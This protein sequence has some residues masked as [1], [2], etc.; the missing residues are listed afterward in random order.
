MHASLMRH[1]SID[2][3]FAFASPMVQAA[4]HILKSLPPCINA[5]DTCE[6]TATHKCPI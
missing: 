6:P 1:A 3:R 4:S 2:L 5:T